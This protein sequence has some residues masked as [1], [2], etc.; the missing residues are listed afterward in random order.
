VG[1]RG[2][3]GQV[4]VRGPQALVQI[5]VLDGDGEAARQLGCGLD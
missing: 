4:V 2:L 3:K 1:E 5:G